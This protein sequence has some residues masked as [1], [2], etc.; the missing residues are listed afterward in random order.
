M[1]LDRRVRGSLQDGVIEDE[2]APVQDHP[3]VTDCG[4]TDVGEPANSAA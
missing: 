3:V 4:V 1:I 2:R